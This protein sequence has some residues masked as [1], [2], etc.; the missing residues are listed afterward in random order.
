MS[1]GQHWGRREK[2]S[3][4]GYNVP[5]TFV[6][7]IMYEGTLVSTEGIIM[8]RRCLVPVHVPKGTFYQLPG[9]FLVP[10]T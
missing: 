7:G 9:T 8:C 4:R 6:P 3:Y 5:G 1:V 10:S 2:L